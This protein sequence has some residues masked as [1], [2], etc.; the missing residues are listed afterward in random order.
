[1][2]TAQRPSCRRSHGTNS[3]DASWPPMTTNEIRLVAA[4]R[5]ASTAHPTSLAVVGR[6]TWL[7]NTRQLSDDSSRTRL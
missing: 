2:A 3:S 7:T 4:S 1:M 6:R 5:T